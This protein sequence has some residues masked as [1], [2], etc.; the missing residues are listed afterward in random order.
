MAWTPRPGAMTRRVAV[1][2]T[3][4]RRPHM[5]SNELDAAISA[6]ALVR[7]F[8]DQHAVAG[9]DLEVGRGEVYGFLGPNGAGKSTTVRMLCT[10]LSPTSGEASV[11]GFDVVEHP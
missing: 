5:T 4:Q 1:R 3:G 6:R 10:L 8:D 11:A 2:R 9:V 7:D